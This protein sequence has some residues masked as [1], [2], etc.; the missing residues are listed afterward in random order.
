MDIVATVMHR[1]AFQLYSKSGGA[2]AGLD[3]RCSGIQA[4]WAEKSTVAP[5]PPATSAWLLCAP[6][7]AEHGDAFCNDLL[8]ELWI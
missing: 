4:T 6:W 2:L 5:A 1:E 3:A 7:I 8:D